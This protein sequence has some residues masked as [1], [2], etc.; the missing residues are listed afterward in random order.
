MS[1]PERDKFLVERFGGCW[2]EGNR[3]HW[4]FKCDECGLTLHSPDDE[5]PDFSTWQDFGW[6]WRKMRE[7]E[8]VWHRFA[9]YMMSCRYGD[10][11]DFEH[12]CYFLNDEYVLATLIDSPSSFADACEGFLR[13]ENDNGIGLV[14]WTYTER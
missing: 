9:N 7:D 4:G 11:D 10:A 2:H 6:L 1:N 3:D 13:R 14:Q 5:N 8:K 12:A